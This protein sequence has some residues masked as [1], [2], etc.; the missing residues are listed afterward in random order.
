M[1]R[2]VWTVVAALLAVA[3]TVP[4][5]V[6]TAAPALYLGNKEDSAEAVIE[7]WRTVRQ[8]ECARC[9]GRDHDGLAA[10]SVLQF[11]R[12]QSRERFDRIVL[13]GDPQRGMPGYGKTPR[14][15]DSIDSI[16]LYFLL[17]AN[18]TI[19]RGQPFAPPTIPEEPDTSESGL[20]NAGTGAQ[21]QQDSARTPSN[22]REDHHEPHPILISF[23]TAIATLTVPAVRAD[24][25]SD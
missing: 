19:G 10:P 6:L 18:G 15:A 8:M 17:R 14:V 12:T 25:G 2:R 23:A 3:T 5:E 13:D 16:Y 21:V 11:V 4:R 1:A 9:H 22:R 24:I 20:P 7:A